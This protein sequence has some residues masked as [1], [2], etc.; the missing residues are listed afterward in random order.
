[1]SIWGSIVTEC[2]VYNGGAEGNHFQLSFDTL[3]LAKRFTEL[4]YLL[5]NIILILNSQVEKKNGL[6]L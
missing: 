2:D 6:I 5:D 4:K 3:E 1:M